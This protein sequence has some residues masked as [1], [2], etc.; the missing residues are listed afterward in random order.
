ME[1]VVEHLCRLDHLLPKDVLLAL[2]ESPQSVSAEN[3]EMVELLDRN[4]RDTFILF[5]E[6]F[7]LL[8]R[9]FVGPSADY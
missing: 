4:K 8:L 3:A 9:I 5:P 1:C 2:D 6:I 7:T